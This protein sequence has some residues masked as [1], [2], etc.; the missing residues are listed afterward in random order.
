MNQMRQRRNRIEFYLND[1]ELARLNALTQR[2]GYCRSAW[3][4]SVIM[5]Y[6]LCE[7]P[8]PAFYETMKQLTHFGNNLNQLTAKAHTLGFI[9]APAL[10]REIQQWRAFRMDI[11]QAYLQPRKENGNGGM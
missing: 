8:D 7:K 10:E 4:R 2:S 9:D 6:R 1:A 3:F 11:F 5:G